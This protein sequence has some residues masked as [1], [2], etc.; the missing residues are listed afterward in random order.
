MSTWHELNNLI[1]GASEATL[2]DLLELEKAGPRR[3]THLRR[4]HQAYSTMR[5]DRERAEV[6]ALAVV[7]RK[8]RVKNEEMA[9]V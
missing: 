9:S 5:T 7:S 8:K 3:A 6:M 2:R 4:L 1:K